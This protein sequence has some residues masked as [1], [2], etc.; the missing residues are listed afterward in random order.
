MKDFFTTIHLVK[1]E[2]LNNHNSLY[3]G[4]LAEWA[5]ESAYIAAAKTAGTRGQMVC[6]NVREMQFHRPVRNGDLLNFSSTIQTVGTTSL[7][8]Y[9]KAEV[10]EVLCLESEAIFV[11]VDHEGKKIPHGVATET[12]S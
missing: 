1:S 10:S 9:T 5:V 6:V 12:D 11:C 8:V 7:T 4:R 2:D 3:A